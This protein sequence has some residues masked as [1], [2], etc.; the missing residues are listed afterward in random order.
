MFWYD[1]VV[2]GV[3]LLCIRVLDEIFYNIFLYVYK[4]LFFYIM[5]VILYIMSDKLLFVFIYLKKI[6][7]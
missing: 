3:N 6:L 4:I 5:N 2:Y 7:F 1:F